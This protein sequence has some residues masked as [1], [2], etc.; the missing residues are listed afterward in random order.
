M[1]PYQLGCA[2]AFAK[3]GFEG[4]VM[5]PHVDLSRVRVNRYSPNVVLPHRSLFQTAPQAF[6]LN[7]TNLPMRQM[8]QAEIPLTAATPG[9]S[10]GTAAD[11]PQ[12]LRGIASS[13]SKPSFLSRIG[14]ATLR[15]FGKR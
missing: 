10:V 12:A 14:K 9:T 7:R 8:F 6:E 13:T 3:F 5:S 15:T 1:T 2:R 11:S 4:E